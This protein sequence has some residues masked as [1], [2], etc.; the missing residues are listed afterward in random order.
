MRE[1]KGCGDAGS[2]IRVDRSG[3]VSV[4][5]A[6]TARVRPSEDAA[7]RTER[8]VDGALLAVAPSGS[9]ERIVRADRERT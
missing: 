5:Q 8:E 2:G 7:R 6:F 3:E 4:G 9:F 1:K